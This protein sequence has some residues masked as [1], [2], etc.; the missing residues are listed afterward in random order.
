MD[1]DTTRT[2][3]SN[4]P[5]RRWLLEKSC[6]R[7]PQSRVTQDVLGRARGFCLYPKSSRF[8]RCLRRG[9]DQ[10]SSRG[11]DLDSSVGSA[12]EEEGAVQDARWHIGRRLSQRSLHDCSEGR[13][14][15]GGSNLPYD[16]PLP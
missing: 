13:C 12:A 6:L 10:G 9:L 8:Q 14:E 5:G 4:G 3:C 1:P 2:L 11:D 16:T 15:Q 7:P